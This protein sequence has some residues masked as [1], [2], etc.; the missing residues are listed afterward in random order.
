MTTT[1]IIDPITVS[2]EIR[3][4]ND[5]ELKSVAGGGSALLSPSQVAATVSTPTRTPQE[6]AYYNWLYGRRT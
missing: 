2:T 3:E 5:D 4:L 6:Q 1:N